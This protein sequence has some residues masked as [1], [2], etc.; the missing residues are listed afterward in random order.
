VLLSGGQW[1]RIAV[2]RAYF[3]GMRD[4]V[5]LDEPSAGLDA[6]AEYRLQQ[7]IRDQCA[8]QAVLL[9]SHRLNTLSDAH[10]IVVLEDGRVVEQGAHHEL[11][12]ADGAYARLFEL[13]AK[14]YR[15]PGRPA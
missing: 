13:Q 2:A 11:V 9:I 6:E 8:G 7:G 14:G 4:L 1:Q 10:Q 12:S 15:M 3:R 5:I